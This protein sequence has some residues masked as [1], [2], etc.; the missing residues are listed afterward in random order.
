MMVR[1]NRF[2]TLKAIINDTTT[3]WTRLGLPEFAFN[4]Y[5]PRFVLYAA[6]DW[7]WSNPTA[8]RET[9]G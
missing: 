5:P 6:I 7:A 8:S 2:I 9:L 1:S 4:I 3:V